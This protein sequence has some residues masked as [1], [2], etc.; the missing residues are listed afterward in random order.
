[1]RD[2]SARNFP[3]VARGA[4]SLDRCRE[5]AGCVGAR[6]DQPG[7]KSPTII[8]VGMTRTQPRASTAHTSGPA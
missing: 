3:S 7:P 8:T 6:P 4:A 2:P 1:M 5:D